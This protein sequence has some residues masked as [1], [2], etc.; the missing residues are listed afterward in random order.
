MAIG[1]L[2]ICIFLAGGWWRGGR[3]FGRVSMM[4]VE[5]GRI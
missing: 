5:G 1:Q 2:G 3:G 4:A